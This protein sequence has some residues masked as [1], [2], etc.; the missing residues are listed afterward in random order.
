MS[1]QGCLGLRP[2]IL[3]QTYDDSFSQ[4]ALAQSIKLSVLE[5]RVEETFEST[6]VVGTP[7]FHLCTPPRLGNG[8]LTL[9]HSTKVG[10]SPPF[11]DALH[12]DWACFLERD[13]C[14]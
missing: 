7:P 12:E 14:P 3:A 13:L 4:F 11:I 6:R 8:P 10:G 2:G 5:I 9:M 1:T